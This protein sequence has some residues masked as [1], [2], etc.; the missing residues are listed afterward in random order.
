M[1]E[2]ML[3]S[4]SEVMFSRFWNIILQLVLFPWLVNSYFYYT[5]SNI[6]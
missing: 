4:F 2:G 5:F 1:D 6:V 3:I